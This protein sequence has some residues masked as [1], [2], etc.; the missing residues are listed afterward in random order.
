MR[1]FAPERLVDAGLGAGLGIDALDDN[2]AVQAVF[3]IGRR[4]SATCG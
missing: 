4:F 1:L 2:R 3:S